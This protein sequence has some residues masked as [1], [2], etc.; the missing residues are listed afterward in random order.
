MVT[1]ILNLYSAIGLW[2]PNTRNILQNEGFLYYSAKWIEIDTVRV[3]TLHISC[4]GEL[5]WEL[6][7]LYDQ[8]L[9]IWDALWEAGHEYEL[10][11]A[12]SSSMDSLRVEKGYRL[13][14]SDIYTEYNVY[15]AG[16][17]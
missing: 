17:N 4:V 5:G 15:Q 12:R 13:W 9:S 11:T 3:Y 8:S 10:I 1:N 2:G 16:L 6:H 14:G 7:I